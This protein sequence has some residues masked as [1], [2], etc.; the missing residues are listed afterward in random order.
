[1]NIHVHTFGCLPAQC[2]M[3][4]FLRRLLLPTGVT[5]A[6]RFDIAAESCRTMSLKAGRTN[7][8]A[9]DEAVEGYA[10]NVSCW[11]IIL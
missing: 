3:R 5:H 11:S 10:D 1:M 6:L 4:Y 2:S 8:T 7:A 9:L